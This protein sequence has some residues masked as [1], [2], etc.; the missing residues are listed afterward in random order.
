MRCARA[1]LAYC[2]RPVEQL[3]GNDIR[4]FLLYLIQEKKFATKTINLHSVTWLEAF[5]GSVSTEPSVL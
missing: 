5:L 3:G 1:F 4:H 2:H